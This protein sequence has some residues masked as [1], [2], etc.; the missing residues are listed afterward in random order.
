MKKK[1]VTTETVEGELVDIEAQETNEQTASNDDI[2]EFFKNLTGSPNKIRI[3]KIINGEAVFC[4]NV[5]PLLVNE[6]YIH[7][8]FG[9]GRFR[10][11]AMKNGQYIRGGSHEIVIYDPSLDPIKTP[12]NFM[13]NPAGLRQ[14]TGNLEMS[15]LR[16]QINRQ[17][18]FML[19]MLE[20]NNGPGEKLQL[21]EVLQLA[22]ELNPK[23]PDFLSAMPGI[24]EL[25][26][27]AIEMGKE[28]G[29]S[30]DSKVEMFKMIAGS[31][32]DVL[33]IITGMLMKKSN[34]PIA[35]S[36]FPAEVY[37]PVN[38]DA[39][40]PPIDEKA[41]MRKLTIAAIND[42]KGFAKMEIDPDAI[43]DSVLSRITKEPRVKNLSI[44]IVN[45]D[46]S[47]IQ[48]CDSDLMSDPIKSWFERF[49]KGLR[50]ALSDDNQNDTRTRG[51]DSNLGADEKIDG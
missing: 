32:K 30:A 26:H 14:D 9:G 13:Q 33:P 42:L 4:G 21:L 15:I 17:H 46:F 40:L 38:A 16:D 36:T 23:G 41:E 6:N 49:H 12:Y 19:K 37:N 35:S 39:P 3:Q 1:T 51:D 43:L 27:K 2:D 48:K 22:K 44:I 18:E 28:S 11:L 25:I 34:A 50:E 29:T 8:N 7:Q 31:I 5:D 24:I 47:E 10:L 45:Q 20:R